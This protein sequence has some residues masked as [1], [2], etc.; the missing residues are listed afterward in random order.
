[1]TEAPNADS[2][3]EI[4]ELS[5]DQLR[6]HQIQILR[7]AERTRGDVLLVEIDG[8][9]AVLKDYSNAN[10]GFAKFLG[11]FLAYRE[12]KAL[13]ALG[14]VAAVPELISR[15]SSRSLLMTYLPGR[16]LRDAGAGFDWVEYLRRCESAVAALHRR[17][18]VHG[19]LRNATN[20]LIDDSDQPVFVDLVSAVHRGKKWNPLGKLLFAQCQRLDFGAMHKLREKY[21]SQTLTAAD[22]SEWNRRGL[23]E[24]TARYLS[25]LVRQIVERIFRI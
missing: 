16:R 8:N 13:I 25:G 18:V 20:V 10:A 22:R 5:A 19:D 15:P 21:A 14:D 12:A 1:M 17:G 23:L 3:R 2:I 9:R 24:R 4:S 7:S 11:P 6:A